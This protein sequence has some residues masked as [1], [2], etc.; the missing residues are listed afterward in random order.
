MPNNNSNATPLSS[1][2]YKRVGALIYDRVC[3]YPHLPAECEVDYQG[4]NG[5]NHVGFLTVPGGKITKKYVTGAYEAQLP[6]EILLKTM[7]TDN[8]LSFEAESLVDDIADWLEQRPYP[9]LSDDRVVV[10]ILMDS[11]TY[12]SEAQDDGSIVFV[13]NGLIL[14][15]KE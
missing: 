11:T 15:E 13:R 1:S 8:N 7:P 6:F 2:E 5:I 14:Y 10:Q 4:I 9:A 3:T 12:R